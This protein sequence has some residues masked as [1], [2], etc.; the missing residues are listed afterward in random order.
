MIAILK[1]IYASTKIVES[2][3]TSAGFI[4]PLLHLIKHSLIGLPKNSLHREV[5]Q[6]IYDGIKKRLGDWENDDNLMKSMIL[7]P[8]FRMDL[9]PIEKRAYYRKKILDEIMSSM[10]EIEDVVSTGNSIQQQIEEDDPFDSILPNSGAIVSINSDL[11]MHEIEKAGRF[12]KKYNTLK[13]RK[14]FV[15]QKSDHKRK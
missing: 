11:I 13:F 7:E 1:P 14:L 6:A 15:I 10:P 2:H 9:V 3:Q 4:V 12:L 8:K 5:R